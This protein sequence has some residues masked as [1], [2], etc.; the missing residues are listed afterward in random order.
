MKPLDRVLLRHD[1]VSELTEEKERIDKTLADPFLRHKLSKPG[2]A[3]KRRDNLQK[4]LTDQAPEPLTVSEKNMLVVK[5]RELREKW[6][7]GMPTGE[8]MRKNPPGAV[9]HHR[10]WEKANKVLIK[11]WKNIRRQLEPDND[12]KDIANIESYRPEGASDRMRTDAQISGH[13]SYGRI[14]QEN[15]DKIFPDKPNSALNQ[16]IEGEKKRRNLTLEQRD[17]ARTRMAAARAKK[18]AKALIL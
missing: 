10:K 9:D 5:E 11:Q 7:E 13:M 3:I 4:M 17:A 1:Q 12:D 14:P 18:A 6:S 15:W 2:E 16:V 8:V